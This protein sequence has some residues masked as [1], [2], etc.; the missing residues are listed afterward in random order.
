MFARLSRFKQACKNPPS[1]PLER[2]RNFGSGSAFNSYWVS[3][4][5]FIWVGPTHTYQMLKYYSSPIVKEPGSETI[6][7]PRPRS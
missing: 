7:R 5:P 3:L 2:A 4:T 6:A 1:T